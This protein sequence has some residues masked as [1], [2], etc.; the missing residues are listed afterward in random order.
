MRRTNAETQFFPARGSAEGEITSSRV[1]D[2]VRI[3]GR[4]WSASCSANLAPTRVQPTLKR[5]IHE[6]EEGQLPDPASCDVIGAR[7]PRRFVRSRWASCVRIS[8]EQLRCFAHKTETARHPGR[9]LAPYPRNSPSPK[10]Q[11][12][13]GSALARRDK[14]ASELGYRQGGRWIAGGEALLCQ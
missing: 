4:R 1:G 13:A 7:S 5:P 3:A 11:P 8:P 12:N 14:P 2:V 10:C 6:R 9:A